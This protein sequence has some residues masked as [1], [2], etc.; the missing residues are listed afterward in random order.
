MNRKATVV[1]WVLAAAG[2][3]AGLTLREAVDRTL[4]NS[5]ALAAADATRGEAAAEAR[6]ARDAFHP[7]AWASTTPGYSSGLPTAIA[8]RVPAIAGVDIRQTLYDKSVRSQ[9][10]QSDALAA[11]QVGAA[12]KSRREAARSA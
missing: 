11:V 1:L 12:E 5:P 2:P 6:L 4:A 9:A 3:A 7:E 8:G 10:F